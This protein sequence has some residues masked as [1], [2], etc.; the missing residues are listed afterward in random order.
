ML[1]TFVSARIAT[2]SFAHHHITTSC[3][4]GN[5]LRVDALPTRHFHGMTQPSSVSL[6][7]IDLRFDK[8]CAI[9]IVDA[10]WR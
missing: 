4:C 8:Q 7:S 10:Q 6:Q 3:S 5:E 2:P 9:M 1:W